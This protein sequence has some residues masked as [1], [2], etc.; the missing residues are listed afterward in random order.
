MLT[1]FNQIVNR[2]LQHGNN[3]LAIDCRDGNFGR[4]SG[5]PVMREKLP[6]MVARISARIRQ[7]VDRLRS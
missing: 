7:A 3:L 4:A 1:I 5:A 2:I 6:P